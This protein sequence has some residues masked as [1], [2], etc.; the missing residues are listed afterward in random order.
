MTSNEPGEC[1]VYITLPGQTEPVVAGRYALEV[2]RQGVPVGRFVYGRSYLERR[3]A[4]PLDPIELKLDNGTFETNRL[5]G[6]FGVLRDSSPDYWGRPG[7]C[8]ARGRRPW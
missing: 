7:G 3:E 6:V 4:V 8:S 5:K 1:F 2:N